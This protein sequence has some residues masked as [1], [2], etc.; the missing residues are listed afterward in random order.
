V[1]SLGAASTDEARA[2]ED[3]ADK[4]RRKGET[5]KLVA[6]AKGTSCYL[7]FLLSVLAAA[8]YCAYWSCHCA[9]AGLDFACFYRTLI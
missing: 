7:P 2:K 4:K 9:V 5:A 6:A 1:T 8:F 3:L